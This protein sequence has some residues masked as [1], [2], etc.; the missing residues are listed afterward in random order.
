VGIIPDCLLK[1]RAKKRVRLHPLSLY[2]PSAAN[3]AL[4]RNIFS[5]EDQSAAVIIQRRC[6]VAQEAR[7]SAGRPKKSKNEGY[8]KLGN[9]SA[10]PGVVPGGKGKEGKTNIK[11]F[12]REREQE[13]GLVNRAMMTSHEM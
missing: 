6:V 2:T 9:C 11:S 5:N 12:A 10:E 7:F 8:A 1:T 3:P 13:V 4:A